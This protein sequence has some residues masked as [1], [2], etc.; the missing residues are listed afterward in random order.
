VTYDL[1]VRA[2][3][4][5]Y[6][7]R[8]HGVIADTAHGF[9]CVNAHHSPRSPGHATQAGLS[10]MWVRA[11]VARGMRRRPGHGHGGMMAACGPE[12]TQLKCVVVL[13]SLDVDLSTRKVKAARTSADCGLPE[14]V[15]APVFFL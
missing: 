5:N 1:H 7:R 13:I 2:L 14:L 6:G 3:P 11:R 9:V 15:P 10:M 4:V 12:S 8:G